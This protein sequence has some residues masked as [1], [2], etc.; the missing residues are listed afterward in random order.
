MES[1]GGHPFLAQISFHNCHIPFIGTKSR[2]AACNAT[3]SCAPTLPEAAPFSDEELDFYACLNEFD[4]SVG[5]VLDFLKKEQT[6]G[7]DPY[8]ENTMIWF[9]VDNGSFTAAAAETPYPL[10]L[11]SLHR[12]QA[13]R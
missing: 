1:L 12:C 7:G 4:S 2:K 10:N 9:T 13:Q 5:T 11:W 6:V 8:Y 3:E